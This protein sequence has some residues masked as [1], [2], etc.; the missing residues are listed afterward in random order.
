MILAL[1]ALGAASGAAAQAPVATSE[2]TKYAQP[3]RP[4]GDFELLDQDG[5][6]FR[7]QQLRGQQALVFFGF[8]NC[9][10]VCPATLQVLR[11]ARRELD[12]NAPK[13]VLISVDGERDTPEAMKRYLEAFGE[14]FIG[15]TGPPT[16]IRDIA[17]GFSAVFFKGAPADRS[18][19]YQVEH[20]SQ[21]YLVDDTG[22]LAAT[23]YGASAE[24]IVAAVRAQR[25]ATTGAGR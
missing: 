24:E 12:G 13:V 20:T 16:Q 18:G 8:T 19:N 7:F 10:S 4:V 6:A 21:V 25:R 3:P 14:G 11:Q 15:L 23:F 17:A 9:A 5:K 2:R 22:G 1:V